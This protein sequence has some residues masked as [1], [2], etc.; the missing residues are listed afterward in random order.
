MAL[1]CLLVCALVCSELDMCSAAR[2]SQ[3]IAQSSELVFI[4]ADSYAC[5]VL[6]LL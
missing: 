6:A 1:V 3:V 2:S 4:A 5:I